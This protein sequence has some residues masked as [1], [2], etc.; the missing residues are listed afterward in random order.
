M[1]LFFIV[2]LIGFQIIPNLER[3]SLSSCDIKLMSL[4]HFPAKMFPKVKVLDVACFHEESADF[5]F[6]F[7]RKFY[8]LEKLILYN[9]NFEELLPYEGVNKEKHDMEFMP[10]RS[11]RLDLLPHLRQIWQLNSAVVT[12]VDHNLQSLEVWRCHHLTCL[13]PC[14]GSLKNLTTLDVWCCNGLA[15]ILACSAAKTLVQLTTLR[16]REC[17]LVTEIIANEVGNTEDEIVFCQLKIL[18]L[19]CLQ[20]GRAHV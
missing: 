4:G 11:L 7:L 14:S 15:N 17:N 2:L 16:I 8:S 12:F 9:S 20:I 6:D 13:L 19:S 1:Y 18:E 10:V 3:L 5:P